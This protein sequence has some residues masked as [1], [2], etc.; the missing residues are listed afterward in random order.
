MLE[1]VRS[2]AS[3]FPELAFQDREPPATPISLSFLF[4]VIRRRWFALFLCLAA[5]LGLAVAYIAVTPKKYAATVTLLIDSRLAQLS[6]TDGAAAVV[7]QAAVESQIEL[8]RSEKMLLSVIDKLGL[9]NDP[10][11]GS[12]NAKTGQKEPVS[13]EVALRR[14]VAILT[15]NLWVTRV[16]RSYLVSVTYNST[17][18]I[19]AARIGNEVAGA[20]ISDQ[21]GAKI[22]A[23]K[24]QNAWLDAQVSEMRS[25]AAQTYRAVQDF[26]AAHD[27]NPLRDLGVQSDIDRLGAEAS[28]ARATT[29]TVRANL[30]RTEAVLAGQAPGEGIV[31][32]ERG[33]RGFADPEIDGLLGRYAE[34]QAKL[35]ATAPLPP[36]EDAALK[37]ERSEVI[38]QLWA[39][40]GAIS[41]Q[42]RSDWIAASSRQQVLEG[43]LADVRLRDTRARL[44][45]ER[46]RELETEAAT[47]RALYES[48]LNQ[49]T[50][51]A[52]QQPV[53]ASDARVIS[54]ATVPL[55]PGT[56]KKFLVAALAGIA[57]MAFGLAGIFV[58]ETMDDVVRTRDRLERAS[59]LP[60]VG[61]V[62]KARR[63]RLSRRRTAPLDR[64][65]VG[66]P[67]L[68]GSGPRSKAGDTLRSLQLSV[69]DSIRTG[70][71]VMGVTSAV[72][73]EGKT[74][75]ALNLALAAY[76]AGRRV[77]LVD[78]NL[79]DPTLTRAALPDGAA[80][81]PGFGLSCA[82]QL[83]DGFDVLPASPDNTIPGAELPDQLLLKAMLAEA[84][85]AY[86][87]VVVDLPA[88]LPLAELRSVIR[89]IDSVVLVTRWGSTTSLQIERALTRLADTD[90]L[91]GVVLNRV[92]LR[93]MRR[94][95]GSVNHAYADR[96]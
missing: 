95:E 85:D 73:G 23:A 37:A 26:K 46:L 21:I 70:A 92:K 57:G 76:N 41:A 86:D 32:D 52:Q 88:I 43:A 45:Q 67:R 47:A 30:D 91:L 90:R 36:V 17:D 28:R 4:D 65:C 39:R 59:G 78:C 69:Y 5:T 49:L 29:T 12:V 18:P 13:A 71:A 27:F 33:L 11:F 40:I 6:Q 19:K 1:S 79:R 89:Q 34:A 20:Y 15:G 16:G 94:F 31:P 44:I 72:P 25:R 48:Y 22:Q 2:H 14:A 54:A 56:P 64:L 24:D 61:L 81:A 75:V 51:A 10:E 93:A 82:I 53:P 63:Q 87:L 8:L 38:R 60:C 96:P 42:Q 3:A 66:F 80:V 83:A 55:Y 74:T 35:S 77:L 50:H 62:P 84:R 58:L 68:A 9:V 7:D